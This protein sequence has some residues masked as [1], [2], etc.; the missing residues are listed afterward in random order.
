MSRFRD[1]TAAVAWRA[2]HRF[3]SNPQFLL[4]SLIFP[5]FFFVAFAG[6]LSNVGNV[7]GFDFP[8]GYTAFQ[9]V[10][11]LLQASAFGGVFTGFSIAADFES[12][13]SRR[14]FLAAPNRLGVLA[15]YGIAAGVR[16]VMVG[17]L[18]FG[19]A[20]ATG[21]EVH[22]NG[23]D[24][25]GLIVLALLVNVTAT[26]WAAGVA[27]RLRTIQAGPAI[28]IPVFLVLFLAPVYVPLSLLSGW[29]EAVARINPFTALVE[30]G[31][32]LI[33]GGDVR[34]WLVY[35]AVL[36]LLALFAVW[37]VRGLRRAEAAG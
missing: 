36:A 9:F 12:G 28:Q 3:V 14:L 16:A 29:V 23:V 22:G 21:M 17:V 27:M 26:L 5:L 2:I 31:R 15:G 10:F 18:L 8:S 6:G 34:V 35:G 32:D 19:V 20:I 4:P 1:V 33:S 25:F 11:V 24:L 13:F 30:G 37:G 7:P